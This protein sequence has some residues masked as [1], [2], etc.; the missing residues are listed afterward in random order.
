[1][2]E[3]WNRLRPRV[4]EALQGIIPDPAVAVG[5][6]QDPGTGQHLRFLAPQCSEGLL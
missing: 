6:S 4:T 5:E 1:M 3:K 2:A